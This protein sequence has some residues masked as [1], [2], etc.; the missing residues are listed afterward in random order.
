VEYF[1]IRKNSREVIR[2][3]RGPYEGHDITRLQIWYKQRDGSEYL[4]GRTV[5][6]NSELIPGIIEG[7]LVAA[8]GQPRVDSAIFQNSTDPGEA[9]RQILSAHAQPLHWEVV[10]EFLRAEYPK[11]HLSKWR[12]YNTLL[13]SPEFR[14]E[15]EDVFAASTRRR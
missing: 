2:I 13:H 1:Q 11:L 8:G 6:F 12:V 15:A 10:T 9:L 7:L 5:A 3:S 4:P 14:Q